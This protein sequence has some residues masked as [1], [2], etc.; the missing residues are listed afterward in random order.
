MG[1]QVDEGLGRI[2]MKMALRIGVPLLALVIVAVI[3]LTV[4]SSPK[5]GTFAYEEYPPD[6]T[7][8]ID[9]V[10]RMTAEH[11]FAQR[12][13]RARNDANTVVLKKRFRALPIPSHVVIYT[14]KNAGRLVRFWAQ[15][16][17]L[18]Y[19]F[20]PDVTEEARERIRRM[21]SGSNSVEL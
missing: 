4:A 9:G 17:Q 1:H 12:A 8:T 10:A 5:R 14:D 18:Y 13:I 2:A 15:G 3:S 20:Y 16:E 7:S 11:S 19:K 6:Y 21:F